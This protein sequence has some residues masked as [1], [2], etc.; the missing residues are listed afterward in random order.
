MCSRHPRED[1]V[2]T[3]R[4]MLEL[5]AKAAGI[6]LEF[7][8]YG[9]PGYWSEW[10]GLPQWEAWN[11]LTDDGDALRLAAALRM[12]VVWTRDSRDRVITEIPNSIAHGTN[13]DG[14]PCKAMRLVIT[15][16]AAEIGRKMP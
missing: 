2:M 6:V 16:A 13:A 7:N 11:P 15:R 10:R 5:A 14:D 1:A 3:D 9:Q 8:D 12:H 4:E